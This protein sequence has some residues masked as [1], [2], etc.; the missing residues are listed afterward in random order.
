MKTIITILLAIYFTSATA[1]AD[2]TNTIS[3]SCVISKPA[4]HILILFR[5]PVIGMPEY[6]KTLSYF[7]A[8]EPISIGFCS[9]TDQIYEI[10]RLAPDYGYR[11]SAR[12]ED[13]QLVQTTELGTQCGKKF[14]KANDYGINAFDRSG[15]YYDGNILRHAYGGGYSYRTLAIRDEPALQAVFPP[16]QDLFN[17]EKPGN[18][19]LWIEY[20][21]FYR[22]FPPASTNLYLVR[23]PPLKLQVL[24]REDAKN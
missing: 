11:L 4:N 1:L 18:Y 10:Y 3:T 23:F 15:A 8:D 6:Y 14:D 7:P 9:T 21:C 17:F 22:P 13:G 16:P 12:S 20:Q 19:T 2:S 24:K 5:K